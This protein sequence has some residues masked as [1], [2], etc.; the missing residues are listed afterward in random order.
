MDTVLQTA[1][2]GRYA[3]ELIR[4]RYQVLE[5]TVGGFY[6]WD[7]V[8]GDNLRNKDGSTMTFETSDSA[9]GFADG[10]VTSASKTKPAKAPKAPKAK[11]A[12]E[13]KVKVPRKSA[14]G[15]IH[16]L[17]DT[18]DLTDEE[19]FARMVAEFPG[20]TYTV[21]LVKRVRRDKAAQKTA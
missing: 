16:E 12:R 7:N 17:I 18:T 21:S 1:G 3:S 9:R 15:L 4:D 8:R 6:I 19:I 20:K 11:L 13:S 14:N 5:S 10:T 2:S